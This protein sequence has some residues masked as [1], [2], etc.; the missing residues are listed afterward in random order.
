[1][2]NAR[3]VIATLTALTLLVAIP[4]TASATPEPTPSAGGVFSIPDRARFATG[5]IAFWQLEDGSIP[6]FSP[7]G[8]TA[9]AI[10]A[11]V[12]ARKGPTNVNRATA[13]LRTSVEGGAIDD[14]VG[15]TAKVLLSVIAS[16]RDP[17][18]FGG[19]DLINDILATEQPDGR[20]GAFT[21]VF[22]QAYAILALTGAGVTPSANARQWLADAQCGD[23]GWQYDSPPQVGEDEHCLSI[24]DPWGD[25]F[26]A[27]TNTTALAVQAL[28]ASGGPTPAEDPFTFFADIRD[29]AGH[30]GWGYTWG[31]NGTDA[32]STAL[33]IQAY[34][35]AGQPL[36]AGA[37]DALVALHH[38]RCGGFS[39]GWTS[40][41][42][43]AVR[44]GPDLGATIGAL[45]GLLL[46]PLPI[47][48]QRATNRAPNS[49][50]CL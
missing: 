1:M 22:D 30:G 19:H 4:V 44:T 5:Y 6:A 42:P 15:L 13:F 18:I 8:S 7:I 14:N 34:V 50:G 29:I 3:R 10:L 25:W 16:R 48:P 46:K 12:A 41:A 27:D 36:P 33:V 26:Q 20:Y 28:Q 31:W 11:F 49:D 17:R 32:N 40:A 24:A 39:Y 37:F 43:D 2:R 23:G 38:G 47:A 21:S 35:A 9:D 45:P